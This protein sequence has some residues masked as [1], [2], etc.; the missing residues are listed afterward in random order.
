MRFQQEDWITID[1]ATGA[2]FSLLQFCPRAPNAKDE[3]GN[4]RWRDHSASGK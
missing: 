4:G 1:Y 3:P 2:A